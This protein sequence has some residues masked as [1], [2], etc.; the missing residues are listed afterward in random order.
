MSVCLPCACVLH[1]CMLE[2]HDV[3]GIAST[4]TCSSGHFSGRVSEGVLIA[5]VLLLV[6]V[7]GV[8]ENARWK[9]ATVR[10][11]AYGHWRVNARC[12]VLQCDVVCCSV[13][14]YGAVCCGALQCVAV[15]CSV[16]QCSHYRS[17]GKWWQ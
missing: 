5:T 4:K 1:V 17:K 12:S 9:M 16:V 3:L 13:L 8:Q 14:Q 15:C 7:V 11:R 10:V 6:V 2:M